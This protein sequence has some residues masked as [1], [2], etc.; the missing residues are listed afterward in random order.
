MSNYFTQLHDAIRAGTPAAV[1]SVVGGARLGKSILVMNETIVAGTLGDRA[2]EETALALVRTQIQT[3]TP[4]RVRQGEDDLFVDLYLPPKRLLIV[5][6]VHAA[7]PLVTFA[8]TLGFQTTVLDAR[9]VF[10]TADRFPH[11]DRL[12][13][14]WPA[15]SLAELGLDAS[16][17]VVVLTHDAKIDTPALLL[18][19][20]SPAVYIGALGSRRTHAARCDALRALGATDEQLA[21]IHAPIGLDLGGRRPEE[22][23]LAIMAEIVA[24]D[25]GRI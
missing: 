20:N 22:I 15:D 17:Y 19:L 21:R 2:L 10:A 9:A 7:I 1:V 12:I 3:R 25:H 11:A 5:G 23:A 24:A 13:V 8:R 6:A 4:A 14:G 18:A 16:S